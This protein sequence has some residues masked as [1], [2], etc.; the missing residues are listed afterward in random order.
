MKLYFAP[1]SCFLDEGL[2]GIN[3]TFLQNTLR[4]NTLVYLKY[5]LNVKV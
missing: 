2:G 1:L 3:N 4:I 5:W